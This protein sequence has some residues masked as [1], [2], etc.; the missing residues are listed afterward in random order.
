MPGSMAT[1]LLAPSPLDCVFGLAWRE[2]RKK[3]ARDRF[4]SC[5]MIFRFARVPGDL[6]ARYHPV[7]GCRLWVAGAA[8]DARERG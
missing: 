8:R 5:L 3:K 2:G 4:S 1:W 7:G 6:P